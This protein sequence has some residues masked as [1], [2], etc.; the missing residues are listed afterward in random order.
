MFDTQLA[1]LTHTIQ[2]AVAPVF[3]LT[4]LGTLLSVLSGRLGRIVDRARLLNDRLPGLDAATA[5]P[6]L[7]ELR[8]LGRRRELINYALTTAVVAALLVCLLIASAFV[9]FLLKVNF[10]LLIAV[11]FV[12]AMGAFISG[13]VLFLREVLLAV[14]SITIAPR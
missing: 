2:L 3:L 6:L 4:A 7:E 12:C 14:A 5:R 8:L 11:L 9:G 13:L 1:D 10:S